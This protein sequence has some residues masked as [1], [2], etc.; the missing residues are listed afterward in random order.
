MVEHHNNNCGQGLWLKAKISGQ[1]LEEKLVSKNLPPLLFVNNKGKK[2]T[3][4]WRNLADNILAKPARLTSPVKRCTNSTYSR[5]HALGRAQSLQCSS[6][7]CIT[8]FKLWENIR[9]TEV[10]DSLQ[11][12]LPI[13]FKSVQVMKGKERLGNSQFREMPLRQ[14][15]VQD[16]ILEQREV[17]V[18]GKLV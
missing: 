17:S 14:G 5:Y 18:V 11:C 16:W 13:F 8:S 3:L 7:E 12:D 2:I 9:Q 6:Q 1:K 15:P 10:R 4:Q